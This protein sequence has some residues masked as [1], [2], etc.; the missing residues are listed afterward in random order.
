MRSGSKATVNRGR[1]GDRIRSIGNYRIHGHE[2]DT[3]QIITAIKRRIADACYAVRDLDGREI[4]ASAERVVSNTRH[5]VWN[6]DCSQRGAISEGRR[7]NACYRQARIKSRNGNL[8]CRAVVIRYAVRHSILVNGELKAACI[9]VRHHETSVMV[10]CVSF[11]RRRTAAVDGS[12][13]GNGIIA[14]KDRGSRRLEGDACQAVAPSERVRINTG[15]GARDRNVRQAT[16][17]IECIKTD[18][19]DAFGNVDALQIATPKECIISDARYTAIRRDYA[20]LTSGNQ[21]FACR[22]D[23]AVACG[24]IYRIIGIHRDRG[25][26]IGVCEKTVANANNTARNGNIGQTLAVGKRRTV[27]TCYGKVV[28]RFRN[29]NH[30]VRSCVACNIIRCAIGIQC[31]CQT[32][33]NK[34]GNSCCL[35]CATI[36]AGVGLY[37]LGR[38][39]R[40]DRDRAVIPNMVGIFH[41][42]ASTAAD[43]LG[44]AV[45]APC[46]KGTAVKRGNGLGLGRAAIATRVG[47]DTLDRVGRFG[48]DLAAIPDV[49]GIFHL[50]ASTAADVLGGTVIAPC[51]ENVRGIERSAVLLRICL[52]G[53]TVVAANHSGARDGIFAI[54]NHDIFGQEGDLFNIFLYDRFALIREKEIIGKNDVPITTRVSVGQRERAA[55]DQCYG[56]SAIGARNDDL[57]GRARIARDAVCRAVGVGRE[58]KAHRAFRFGCSCH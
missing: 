12:G 53:R 39:G 10:V 35:G 32:F 45:I 42:A 18:A 37:A 36:R 47:L 23:Q 28:V 11:C 8:S 5:A 56:K 3:C 21:L 54:L 33:A 58:L 34:N 20:V 24:M 51:A 27:D 19:G 15:N 50:A 25:Q 31:K 30:T 14:V 29:N 7:A 48:R 49:V 22:I 1:C 2:D 4:G 57:G 46:A 17:M 26:G 38:V 52:R 13:F 40:R 16:T 6:S 44:C 43:V 55:L 41:L 9:A